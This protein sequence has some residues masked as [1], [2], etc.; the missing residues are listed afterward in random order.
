VGGRLELGQS[1]PGLAVDQGAKPDPLIE[2]QHGRDNGRLPTRPLSF[3]STSTFGS[4]KSLAVGPSFGAARRL[5][6]GRPRLSAATEM[7]KSDLT[8]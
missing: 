1:L 8:R 7:P 4:G 2:R 6:D 3:G 5:S